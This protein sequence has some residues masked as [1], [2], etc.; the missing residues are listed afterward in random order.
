MAINEQKNPSLQKRLG[1]FFTK[2]FY[3]KKMKD[4]HKN[5][6]KLYKKQTK[7]KWDA[8]VESAK[9]PSFVKAV[10]NDPRSDDKL[11]M[12]TSRMNMMHNG[13]EV[14]TYNG[15][16]GG[17]YSVRRLS[18]GTYGCTCNHWRYVSSV[19]PRNQC[20]HIKKYLTRKI[21]K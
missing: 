20:K 17:T 6:D 11:V 5:L 7:D 1:F 4:H 14:A 9:D 21:I 2:L 3:G 8:F 13:K 15:S 19:T 10:K 18:D 12:H 16:K